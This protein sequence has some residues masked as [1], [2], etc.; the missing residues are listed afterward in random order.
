MRQ[1]LLL[2]IPIGLSIGLCSFAAENKSP[3]AETVT[4]A[5]NYPQAVLEGQFLKARLYLP[6][7]KNGYYRGTRFDWS[8][9][10]SRVGYGAH[11]FFCEFK[12]EHDPLNHD[13]V[14]GTAEEFDIDGPAS[15]F[16]AKAGDP[17]IKIG[18][19]ILERP[20]DSAYSF[21]K[22]YKILKP[23]QWKIERAQSKITFQQT[24]QGP[25]GWGYDYAKTLELV[26]DSPTLRIVR[27]L[28]NT[29]SQPIETSHYGHNFLRID[30]VPAGT[31]CTL[32]FRFDPHLTPDSRGQGCVEVKGRQLIFPS[33]PPLEVGIW[34]RME[35]FQKPEDNEI[36]V[37]NHRSESAVTISTVRPLGK[38]VFYSSGRV[39]CPEPFVR[40]AINPGKT[41][42]WTTTYRFT[43][44]KQ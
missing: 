13:D 5:S 12:Q 37:V 31:N 21:W 30:D 4:A 16:Q 38:L 3:G 36:K 24:L 14:C 35:G 44:G 9:L 34:V 39:L 40:W 42:E 20:D 28:K 7:S 15:F 2:L 10:I 26:P 17:F 27:R 11:S 22:R 29:G 1:T 32:D 41:Q 33:N 43:A 19:G 18:V 6:D 23:G 8:G 25:N